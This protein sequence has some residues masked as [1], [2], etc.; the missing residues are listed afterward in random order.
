MHSWCPMTLLFISFRCQLR[1]CISLGHHFIYIY[2][3]VV[4]KS[5]CFYFFILVFLFSICKLKFHCL[6]FVRMHV[7]SCIIISAISDW[8]PFSTIVAAMFIVSIPIWYRCSQI[9]SSFSLYL[10]LTVY[11]YCHDTYLVLS[12]FSVITMVC[13]FFSS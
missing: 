11:F 9:L 1:F 8:F 4:F 12:L 6:S 5:S 10:Y 3:Y 2:M 13:L 7:D